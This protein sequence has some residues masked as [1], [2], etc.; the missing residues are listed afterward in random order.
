M[1]IQ[2]LSISQGRANITTIEFQSAIVNPERNPYSLGCHS[3]FPSSSCVLTTT[4]LLSLWFA[5]YGHFIMFTYTITY[6]DFGDWLI[7]PVGFG[8]LS[9]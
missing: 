9:T 2:G 4:N 5:S 3:P 6:T 7:P 1:I 8:G